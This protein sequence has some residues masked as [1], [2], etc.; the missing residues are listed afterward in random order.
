MREYMDNGVQ[1]GWLIDPKQRCVE[2]YRLCQ[3]VESLESPALLSGQ[4]LLPGFELK[5]NKVW[6]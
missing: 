2:I 5:L 4:N 6:G 3:P 1:L